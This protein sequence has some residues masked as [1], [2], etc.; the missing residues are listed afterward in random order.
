MKK[1]IAA[2][3]FC[4]AFLV[5]AAPPVHSQTDLG[6]GFTFIYGT[7]GL[8]IC[9]GRWIPSADVAKP[10]VCEGQLQDV[11][12]F[13]AVSARQTAD[14]LN[15]ALRILSAIDQKLAAGN[16]QTNMLIEA[17]VNTQASVDQLREL[18]SAS[19]TRKF[20]A[21]PKDL[22]ANEQFREALTQLKEEILIELDGRSP[23]KP[24]PQTR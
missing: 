3:L 19:I 7:R 1:P 10:G 12:M 15:Q 23:Q 5:A 6:E 4:L 8:Q 18:L 21:L 13:N 22:L 24:S 2:A 9:Q 16:E 20:E 17:A 11:G 14:S